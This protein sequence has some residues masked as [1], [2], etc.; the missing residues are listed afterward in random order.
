MVVLARFPEDVGRQLG[1]T[2]KLLEAGRQDILISTKGQIRSQRS[3]VL[4]GWPGLELEITTDGNFV[5]ALVFA[6]KEQIYEVWA[7]VPKIRSKS[8]D[9]QK[10]L[11]SFKLTEQGTIEL[12]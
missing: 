10:F 5:K 1:N 7:H 11:D 4:N 3:I 2:E 12:D 8:E 9:I 6:T